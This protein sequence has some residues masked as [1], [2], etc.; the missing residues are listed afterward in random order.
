MKYVRL[1]IAL[2]LKNR[3]MIHDWLNVIQIID[4]RYGLLEAII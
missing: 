3:T 4:K 2:M 1:Y